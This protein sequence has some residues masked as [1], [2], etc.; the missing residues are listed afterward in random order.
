MRYRNDDVFELRCE[1]VD[2]DMRIRIGW[3]SH[4]YGVSQ[5]LDLRDSWTLELSPEPLLEY[6]QRLVG[7]TLRNFRDLQVETGRE[8][9]EALMPYFEREIFMFMERMERRY[10]RPRPRY[11][12]FRYPYFNDPIHFAADWA[13]AEDPKAKQKARELLLKNLDAGQEKSFKKDGEFRVTAKDGK[14]YTIKTA[15]SFNVVGPDGAKYCGQLRDTPIEDQML[16][17]KLLLEHDPEKF[18]KNA[19]ISPAATAQRWDTLYGSIVND[20]RQWIVGAD[21]DA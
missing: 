17:Q 6:I 15:R 2:Y 9:A 7:G 14:A 4:R 3:R 20:P 8:M 21:F 5:T 16:A 1:R 13:V 11:E 10:A 12:D 18:F 19:N